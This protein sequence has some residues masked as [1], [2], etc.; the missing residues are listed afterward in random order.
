[1][2]LQPIISFF[3]VI[4]L[5]LMFFVNKYRLLY[6]FFRPHY[7]SSTVNNLV[8]YLLGL[9][10]LV[11]GLGMLVFINWQNKHYYEGTLYLNWVI[12]IIGGFFFFFPFKLLYKCIEEPIFPA[13]K[14][15]EMKPKLPSEYDIMNPITKSK[16]IN[17]YQSYLK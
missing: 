13:L 16:A 14:Y 2:S 5:I 9:S 3:A 17:D 4:G 11:F 7:F 15:S 12:F 6:R 1:M 10:P 8:G